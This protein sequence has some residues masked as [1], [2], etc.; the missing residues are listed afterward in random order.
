MQPERSD[1]RITTGLRVAIVGA[2]IGGLSAANVL[3]R[4]GASVHVFELFPT[5]GFA[6]RGGALGFVDTSILQQLRPNAAVRGH[7]KFYGD[8]WQF[9]Y[10]GLPEGTVRFGVDVTRIVA[11]AS[12]SPR[13]V[14]PGGVEQEFDIIIGADGGKSNIRPYVTSRQPE[15]SGIYIYILAIIT[16]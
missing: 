13:L 9:L 15:Y 7:V 4:L 6:T 8:L 1:C 14:L 10:D 2:S 12:V 11:P 16:H 5:H 3:C